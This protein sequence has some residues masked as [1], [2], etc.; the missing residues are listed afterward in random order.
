MSNTTLSASELST[1]GALLRS[2]AQ[3]VADLDV[4]AIERLRRLGCVIESDGGTA[5]C[6]VRSDLT[7]WVD[8][9]EHA[10]AHDGFPRRV[11]VYRRTAST[12]DIARR[13]ADAPIAVFAD[14]QTAGRG[15]L[16]RRWIAPAGSSLLLSL[17]HPL[18][19]GRGDSADRLT[20]VTAVAV[21]QTVERLA[22]R[23]LVQIKWPNDVVAEGRKVAGILVE[24]VQ[25]ARG[26]AAVIGVG[27]NV[28]PLDASAPDEVRRRATSMRQLGSLHD[29]LAIPADLLP[30]IDALLATRRDDQLLDEWRQRNLMRSQRV[31]LRSDG[32]VVEGEVIDLDPELGLL[33]RRDSGEIVHLPAAKTTVIV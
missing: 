10:L 11:E 25:T 31:R 16:G 24:V 18:D 4:H 28:E 1:L 7:V 12:Q 15:R 30:R 20:F 13:R 14:E 26:R 2:P 33:V 22:G 9:L 8:F 19:E 5:H 17:S 3:A 23:E 6:L 32:R 29:R 21:A 27:L